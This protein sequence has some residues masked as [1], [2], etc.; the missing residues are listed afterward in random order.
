MGKKNKLNTNKFAIIRI[1]KW[2]TI[3]LLVKKKQEVFG[4]VLVVELCA[5]CLKLKWWTNVVR[6]QNGSG[7]KKE[8][9]KNKK[10]ALV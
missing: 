2:R 3:G 9:K 8:R 10:K 1:D 7:K 5:T 6:L 4:H